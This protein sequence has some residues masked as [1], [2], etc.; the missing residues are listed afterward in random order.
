MSFIKPIREQKINPYRFQPDNQ[1]IGTEEYYRIKF[2][3]KF[4]DEM[5]KFLEVK[6]R[7]EYDEKDEEKIIND[8]LQY[9]QVYNRLLEMELEQRENEH[10][11]DA[12]PESDLET[13]PSND[14]LDINKLA[15]CE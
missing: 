13:Q 10:K 7:V 8:I 9:R 11:E 12:S 3:D 15:I 14:D 1:T 5:Y 2:G 4:P 6:S